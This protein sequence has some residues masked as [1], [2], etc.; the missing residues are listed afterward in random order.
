[1]PDLHS[2]LKVDPVG[3]QNSDLAEI[4]LVRLQQSKDSITYGLH[5]RPHT[6]TTNGIQST[7][8]LGYLGFARSAC[9]FLVGGECYARAVPSSFDVDAFSPA[10]SQAYQAIQNADRSLMA[11][12]IFLERPEGY[13]FFNQRPSQGQRSREDIALGD[14]HTSPKST[15]LKEAEDEIFTYVLSWIEGGSDK[16]WVIHY[17]PK[18]PPLSLEIQA[19]LSFLNLK[20]FTNCP[21]YDWEQCYWRFQKFRTNANTF[22]ESNAEFAHNSF[23]AHPTNFAPAIEQLL[24]AELAVRPFEMTLLP[25][26]RQ[27]TQIDRSNAPTTI[28]E[29]ETR[30]RTK[31]KAT[32]DYDVAISFAGAD[33]P[34]AEE[35]ATRVRG[36]GIGVFYDHFYPEQLWGKDLAVFFQN[37][38]QKQS[39]FCVIFVSQAYVDGEWT[40]HERRSAVARA[41]SE[42]RGEYILPIK[43][44]SIDLPGVAPTIGYLS[45]NTFPL[46]RIAEMLIKKVREAG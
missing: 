46:E 28:T 31:G 20:E 14:G 38:Y 18:H 21:Q 36:E 34:L 30:S 19:A 13:G 40:E 2:A 12:G 11:C 3:H 23:D 25:K 29:P 32:F 15:R 1:M 8:L 41:I 17:R 35:L 4:T 5:V 44:E 43:V 16:G 42:N 33:R 10:F 27:G 39:R 22:S 9:S 37:I 45:L 7:D 6:W 24:A 26:L